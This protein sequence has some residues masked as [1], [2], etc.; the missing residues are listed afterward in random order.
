MEGIKMRN[1]K[2]PDMF[3]VTSILSKIGL[4][5]FSK[6]F[7]S[8][9]IKELAK[10]EEG[11]K[12]LVVGMSIALN[13]AEVIFTNLEKCEKQIYQLLANLS[14][15]TVEEVMD[16]DGVVFTE[17]IVEVIANPANKGFLE[18]A[19]RLFAKMK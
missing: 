13:I 1:L 16:L 7:Q 2:A 8:E 5:E 11:D 15:L 14:S 6:C 17:M 12:N 4:K 9:E 3:L 19:S 10:T 18:L